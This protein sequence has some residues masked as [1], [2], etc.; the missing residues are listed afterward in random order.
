MPDEQS[1][2]VRVLLVSCHIQ[3][4]EILCHLLQKMAVHAETCCDYTAAMRKLCRAKF[5]GIVVDLDDEKNGLDLLSKLR[6]MTSHKGAVSYAVLNEPDQ[7]AAAF[8]AGANFVFDRPLSAGLVGRTL[9]ASYPLLVRERRRYFRCP[10]QTTTYVSGGSGREFT[11]TSVNLSESGIAI[12]SPIPLRDGERLQLRLQ[13]PG[14][15][16]FVTMSGD[17]CWTDATGRAG[18]QFVRLT[19]KVLEELHAWLSSRLNDS[20]HTVD[21]LQLEHKT[22]EHS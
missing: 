15:T 22:A 8:R 2:A 10:I 7:K 1:A 5:E 20:M 12:N 13:L 4:I 19:R 9:T 14:K 21:S 11:A 3:T 17:V 16:K 18:I 6:G